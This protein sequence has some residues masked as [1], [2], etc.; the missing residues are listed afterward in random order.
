[1]H[2]PKLMMLPI[3]VPR[4]HSGEGGG[5][6][7]GDGPLWGARLPTRA[8]WCPVIRT[9]WPFPSLHQPARGF[10]GRS[11][12][13]HKSF[14]GIHRTFGGIHRPSMDAPPPSVNAPQAS[15]GLHRRLVNP[16]PQTMNARPP[17]GEPPRPARERP[18]AAAID[19]S[20][21]VHRNGV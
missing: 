7:N 20:P 11:V 2:D 10:R 18:G 12:G 17:P 15:P 4:K 8:L 16:R 1:M 5:Y 13:V 9:F 6:R 19:D 14:G 3:T 21:R